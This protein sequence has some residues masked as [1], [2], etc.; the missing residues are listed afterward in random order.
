MQPPVIMAHGAF[1]GGWT[2]DRFRRPFEAAG[3]AVSAPDLPGHGLDQS[4][5][6]LSMRD[7][8]RF[9]AD[10][11]R[12]SATPPIL[13][14]HSMGGLA[15]LMAAT[16]AP[17]TAVILLAPSA[18]WGVSGSTLE[19]AASAFSLYTLGAFWLTAVEPDYGVTRRFSLDRLGRDERKA[20][21]ARMRPESGRA[22]WETLNWWLD[23]M[24]TTSVPPDAVT[25]PILAL[26]GGKDVIH[27]AV[28]VR[29][30]ASRLGARF[31]EFPQMSHWLPGEPGWEEVAAF[32]LDWLATVSLSRPA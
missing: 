20:L 6:G 30:T 22:L 13:I 25:A 9:L 1:C 21:F 28:T 31:H 27:P 5:L 18:P 15:C 26:A 19:E 10:A 14:G 32:G 2:F 29:Q 12:A 17:V 8:A 7:Y 4:A 3:H 23:P 16:K 24:M 11:C